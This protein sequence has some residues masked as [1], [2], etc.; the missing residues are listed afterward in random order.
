MFDSHR[1]RVLALSVVCTVIGT[2]ALQAADL[3]TYRGF[4]FGT[5]LSAAAEQAGMKIGD[6]KL[7]HQ[8]PAL[9][10]VLDVQRYFFHSTTTQE[11]PV[12]E[13]SLSFYNGELFRIAVIYDRYKMEQMTPE[14][15]IDGI[16]ATYGTAERPSAEIAYPSYYSQ[17]APVIAR[18]EDSQYSYNLIRSEERSSFAM[19]LFSKRLD[20][21]AQSAISEAV[22]MDALEAPQRAAELAR[23]QAEENRVKA[24]KSRLANIAGFRP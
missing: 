23:K 1:A 12:S 18:W 8:R 3:S 19:V 9:I 11:D 14:D 7:V 21:L 20:A 4:Q 5:S 24:E 16:S 15:V 13:L 6:A 10:Q 22:R 17:I 2:F